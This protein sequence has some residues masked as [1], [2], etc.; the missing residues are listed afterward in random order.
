MALADRL[1]EAKARSKPPFDL[2]VDQFDDDDRVE[3]FAAVADPSIATA[4]LVRIVR[5]E[6]GAIGK[7]ALLTYRRNHG[8][9][10]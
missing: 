3:W 9:P 5:A 1:K 7:D 10:G 8:F 6:G 4:E 2:W